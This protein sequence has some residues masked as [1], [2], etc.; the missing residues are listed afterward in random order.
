VGG[1]FVLLFGFEK[2]DSSNLL[3]P[4]WNGVFVVV[5]NL[6][7]VLMSFSIDLNEYWPL[8]LQIFGCDTT[9]RTPS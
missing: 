7:M 6:L 1:E 9:S 8:P 4:H 5:F 2:G 3:E